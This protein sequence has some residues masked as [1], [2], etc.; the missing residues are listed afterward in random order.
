MNIPLTPLRCLRYAEEQ[1]PRRT[2][3]VCGDLRF[4][5]AQF[6][7]RAALLAG[8][9]CAA[10]VKP[11]DRVAFL[12]MN[13]HRLLEAY[14]GVLDAG[15]ILLPLNIR[16]GP[17]EL[18]FILN[19]AGAKVLFLEKDFLPVVD[20][21]RHSTTTVESFSLLD[22]APQADWLAPRNYDELLAA[23]EPRRANIME[24]D[25]NAISEIFYT[26]GTSATPKGVMLTHR[27]VYMHAL[28]ACLTDDPTAE[29]VQLHTIPLFH[30]NGWGTPHA[31]ALTGGKHVMLRRFETAAIFRLIEQERV[32]NMCLVPAMATALV[33]CPERTKHDLSS[34]KI[35]NIGGA[36]SSPTLVRET[37]EKLGASC[38]SGYGLTE[39]SPT[40][41]ISRMKPGLDW[42]GEQKYIGQ[43]M[44]GFAIPG[45]ELRV[46]DANE[47]DVPHDGQTIGEI[48]ARSDVVMEGYWG[49]PQATAEAMRGGWFH[50]GD[51]ATINDEGYLLVVDRKKEIIVSGGENI[52]SLEVEKAM[53]AHSSVYEVAVVPVP[54]A[55]W[56]EVPKA[57]VVLKP[58]AQATEAELL[59][60]CR[61]RIAHYK[62]P[63]SVEFFDSLPKTGTGKILKR[64][65]RKK[66]WGGQDTIR[67]EFAS[68]K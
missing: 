36:A 1:F 59:E 27:N 60:F 28:Y 32:R 14:Y 39:T 15:A 35:I 34:L 18:A 25:E 63:R 54:D 68:R 5:Y 55:K 23:A 62:A 48:V 64:E 50:T 13:C 65:L 53:L 10:G 6:A 37:E 66:Y 52:S 8:A 17:Q 9:L 11:G 49:Q 41:S 29:A 67:P 56:G 20:S 61:A 30:A 58:G 26:S 4:T 7:H 47:K 57:L 42:Q 45:V 12:S 43:A 44:T 51:M 22:A 46:V 31:L 21:F 2:A 3:V 38:R 24:I 33:N 19:D 40:L 16:L